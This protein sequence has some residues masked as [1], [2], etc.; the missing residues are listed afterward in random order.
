MELGKVAFH[1]IRFDFQ[2]KIIFFIREFQ[3]YSLL[4]IYYI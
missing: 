3:T 2:I 1:Q 4:H